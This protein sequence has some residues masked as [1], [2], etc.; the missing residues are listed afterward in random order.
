M[1]TARRLWNLAYHAQSGVLFVLMLAISIL[2]FA[3]VIL[4]YVLHHPLMGIEEMLIFPAVWLYLLGG[5]H[6]SQERNQIRARVLE[7]FLHSSHSVHISKVVMAGI[8]SV[9]AVWLAYWAGEY[10]VYALGREK[11]SSSLYWPLIYAESAI[12]VGFLL[13]AIYTLVEFGDYVRQLIA[14]VRSGQE[15]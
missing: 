14:E 12:F 9:V 6:A 5:A 4:R 8:T 2:V 10:F 11:L 15:L 3:E 1:G 7:V 13:M